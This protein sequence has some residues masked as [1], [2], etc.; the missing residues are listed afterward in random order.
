MFE[1]MTK[2]E[3]TLALVVGA[4]V[5]IALLFFAFMWFADQMDMN[6]IEITNLQSSIEDEEDKAFSALK[7]TQ[8][9]DFYRAIS[10]PSNLNEAKQQYSSWLQET[11]E[12]HGLEVS[13][14]SQISTTETLRFEQDPV[15]H[16]V[17]YSLAC[18]GKLD[19]LTS[20]L[21]EFET[22]GLL[23]RM[24]QMN[25]TRP[26]RTI[27]SE[28]S[29]SAFTEGRLSLNMQVEFLSLTEAAAIRELD[30]IVLPDSEMMSYVAE[31]AA[32]EDLTR[33]QIRQ[34]IVDKIVHRNVFAPGNQPP[35]F[36][37]TAEEVTAGKPISFAVRGY[38]NDDNDRITF[39]LVSSELANAVVSQNSA[40]AANFSADAADIGTYLVAVAITDN[41]NPQ[42]RT[43]GE[44]VVTVSP[45][46][47]SIPSIAIEDVPDVPARREA[48]IPIYLEDEDEGDTLEVSIL[49]PLDAG[50]ELIP[51]EDNPRYYEL[52][53]PPAESGEYEIELQVLDD[54]LRAK[55]AEDAETRIPRSTKES[56]KLMVL[57]PTFSFTEASVYNRKA[58]ID[59]IPYVWIHFRLP[60]NEYKQLTIGDEFEILGEDGAW[61]VHDFDF[62]SGELVLQHADT[63]RHYELG[64]IL[65]QPTLEEVMETSVEPATE[66]PTVSSSDSTVESEDNANA[67]VSD[68]QTGTNQP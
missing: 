15:F 12:K 63:L 2:R 31:A 6:E 13:G 53:I 59:N 40:R 67:I 8:R 28:G 35:V 29:G 56:F 25:V 23:H 1:N 19:Q 57:A 11:A 22:A 9:E 3:K 46:A 45:K 54:E 60:N 41:G 37:T 27:E 66:Q 65:S 39:E 42:K 51:D 18:K 48:F 49:D 36:E 30:E 7:A 5:P 44:I 47:N 24:F 64:S 4:L 50:M 21:Y 10:L 62:E 32:G 68:D 34:N 38:D 14:V 43:V 17:Q 55:L 33:D 16:A 26:N 52:Y 58:I 61:V 20:F